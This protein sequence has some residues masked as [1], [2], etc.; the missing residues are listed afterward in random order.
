MIFPF[1]F[2]PNENIKKCNESI[3]SN[4]LHLAKVRPRDDTTS[5]AFPTFLFQVG[6]KKFQSKADTLKN[7]F[8]KDQNHWQ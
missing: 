8:Y 1:N 2:V 3:S 5:S 7:T 4:N 6:H